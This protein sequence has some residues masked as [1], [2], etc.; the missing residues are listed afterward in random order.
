MK[1]LCFCVSLFLSSLC[2]ADNL[3]A[4]YES[5][6]QDGLFYLEHSQH[7][8]PDESVLV[9]YR[10]L[11]ETLR[12]MNDPAALQRLFTVILS[13]DKATAMRFIS[14]QVIGQN[15]VSQMFYWVQSVNHKTQNVNAQDLSD[16]LKISIEL[17]YLKTQ[18]EPQ[19][20]DLFLKEI[21]ETVFNVLQFM[22]DHKESL[23]E[24]Y[25]VNVYRAS[26]PQTFQKAKPQIAQN[27]VVSLEAFR[28]KRHMAKLAMC[29]GFFH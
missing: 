9:A 10:D 15:R 26:W 17:L 3:D 18:A 23:L 19:F 11:I 27:N 24:A 28:S 16:V 8:T 5:A 13:L 14:T 7:V 21:R 1:K 20:K 2:V 29:V 22:V 6:F 12:Q 4:Q 25:F